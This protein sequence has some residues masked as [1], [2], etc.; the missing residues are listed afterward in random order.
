MTPW[1]EFRDLDPQA[2]AAAMRGRTI[3][4]PYGVLRRP[5]G[6]AYFRIGSHA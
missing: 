3:I 4:D 6:F 2:L 5:D 1:P